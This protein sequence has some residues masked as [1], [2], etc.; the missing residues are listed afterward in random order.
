MADF[1][2]MTAGLF[3]ALV[4]LFVDLL[5]V[6]CKFYRVLQILGLG[7]KPPGA[8]KNQKYLTC[9]LVL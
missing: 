3:V 7:G 6:K 5:W 8:S 2:S 9:E 4:W 1:V